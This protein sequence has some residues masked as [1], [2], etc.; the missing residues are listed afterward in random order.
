[1]SPARKQV[2]ERMLQATQSSSNKGRAVIREDHLSI[3]GSAFVPVNPE[4]GRVS[5]LGD[6]LAHSGD[7]FANA[8]DVRYKIT[9]GGVGALH[10]EQI[11]ATG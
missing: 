10:D 2:L 1:M 9:P 5:I 3:G 11:D 7:R 6:R 4:E 8:H